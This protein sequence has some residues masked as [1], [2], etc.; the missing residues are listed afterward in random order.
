[1]QYSSLLLCAAFAVTSVYSHGVV[2]EVQGANSVT[3]P[4]LSVIDDTPRDCPSPLCGAEA[5]TSI[6]VPGEAAT[7]PLGRNS[8]GAVVAATMMQ[9][10]MGGASNT[11][12]RDIHERSTLYRRA[13]AATTAGVATPAGNKEQ[14]VAAAAGKGATAGLPTTDDNGLVS[15]TIH[16]VNQDGAGPFAAMVDPTSGGTDANALQT[17]T[18]TQNVPGI[19]IAG[20]STASVM[21]FPVQM[22]MPAGMT[23]SGSSGGASNVC[24]AKLSNGPPQFFGGS[25]AFTQSGGARKRAIEYRLKMRRDAKARRAESEE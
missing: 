12:A 14:G 10:Y 22:Q 20:I 15:M 17:A 25:I 16:Q 3:M 5:D 13:A 8:K 1:M 4:A 7:M 23:C 6:L 2:T 9:T 24:V 21:D 18:V 11:T 19:G